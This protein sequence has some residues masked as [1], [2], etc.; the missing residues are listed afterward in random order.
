[1]QVFQILLALI[2]EDLHG[3]AIIRDVRVR[4]AGEVRLTASTLYAAIKSACSRTA[5]SR[6]LPAGQSPTTTRAVAITG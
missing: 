4:T 1:M 3:Y 6:S 5:R 2:D